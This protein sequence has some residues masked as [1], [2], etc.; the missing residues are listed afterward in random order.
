MALKLNL[1]PGEKLVINGA[2]IVNGNRKASLAIR[3]FAHILR[4]AD[5]MQE[6]EAITPTR[7]AYFAAQLLLLDPENRDDY[8]PKVQSLISDL[9]QAFTNAEVLYHL[10][11][12]LGHLEDGDY[13]KILAVLRRV[14]RYEDLLLAGNVARGLPPLSDDEMH[15]GDLKAP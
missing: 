4:E 12:A 8:A 9:K 15:I 2:V 7:R 10:D 14:I 5:V 6:E 13:Y 11:K 3:N 1:K